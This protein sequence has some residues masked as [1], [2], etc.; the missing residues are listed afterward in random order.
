MASIVRQ[1]DRE[2]LERLDERIEELLQG[3]GEQTQ[4]IDPAFVG[5][6]V[7]TLRGYA[8]RLSDTPPRALGTE[9]VSEIRKI[10]LQGITAQEELSGRPLDQLDDAMVRAEA[11]RHLLRDALDADVGVD[12]DDARALVERLST[13]LPRIPQRELARLS[14]I[15]VRQLQ[16]WTKLGGV[17]PRRLQIVSRLV[18]LLRL[19]WT[20]EGV[21]AWFERPRRD[22]GGQRPIDVLDDP[23]F[24]LDL[25]EAA[26][27]GRAQHGA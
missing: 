8:L 10:V 9:A 2:E 1:E 23:V 25:L 5:S 19:G 11:V 15:S 21:V 22:L 17:A 6:W 14:G 16:R 4:A 26:R 3:V 12:E 13:W 27:R 18:A 20:P 7:E 24:E